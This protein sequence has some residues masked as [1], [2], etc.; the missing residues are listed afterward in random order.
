MS[1]PKPRLEIL[2]ADAD[3]VSSAAIAAAFDRSTGV[4]CVSIAH[5]IDEARNIL[6]HGRSNALVVDIFGVGVDRGI[7]LIKETRERYL[8]F[9]ICLLGTRR[10]LRELPT[11]PQYWR[12]P[13]DHYYKLAKDQ[14]PQ[15]LQKDSEAMA[16]NLFTYWLARSA[17]VRLSHLRNMLLEMEARSPA[18]FSDRKQEIADAIDLA[19]KAIEEQSA[20]SRRVVGSVPG[21]EARDVQLLATQTLDRASRALDTSTRINTG[22]LIFG[23]LIVTASF[24]VACV[25]HRWDAVAFGGFGL[26]GVVSSLVTNPLKSI[27]FAS[28]RIV[29]IQ[30]AYLGFLNQIAIVRMTRPTRR[31]SRANV[32]R[33]QVRA[34]KK[35]WRST[36]VELTLATMGELSQQAAAGGGVPPPMSLDVGF[37]RTAAEAGADLLSE[38]CSSGASGIR[39]RPRLQTL[40][41]LRSLSFQRSLSN[42]LR[43]NASRA[44]MTTW[45]ATLPSS[46]K[47]S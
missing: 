31:W 28:R 9:P 15:S 26:A 29:Q 17:K 39:C 42:G 6:A 10:N 37:P 30:V 47:K 23:A 32:F 40:R 34:F 16:Y 27:G 38:V 35:P 11:V 45:A 33:R 36:S 41:D 46:S 2:V 20:Q 25:T 5:T 43:R 18:F 4:T 1:D 12:S 14:P 19:Q 24:V 44:I 7:E 3:P 13:F 8:A 22:I 21:F